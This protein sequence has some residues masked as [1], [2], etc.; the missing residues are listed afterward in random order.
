MTYREIE[1]TIAGRD[2]PL[3]GE[4]ENGEN[5]VVGCGYTED[6]EQYYYITTFQ[7]HGWTRTNEYYADGTISETYEK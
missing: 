2:L 1:E 6:G 4:N 7:N 5:V 3:A